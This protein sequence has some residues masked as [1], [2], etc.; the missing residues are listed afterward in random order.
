MQ[1]RQTEYIQTNKLHKVLFTYWIVLVVWQNVQDLVLL[2]ALDIIIKTCL[3]VYLIVS[4]L[5]G[6]RSAVPGINSLIW[7]VMFFAMSTTCISNSGGISF[8]NFIQYVFPV[9]LVFLVYLK[10][11]DYIITETEYFKYLDW[12]IY[13]VLYMA[14]YSFIF[15]GSYFSSAFSIS[16]AYGSALSSFLTSNHEYGMYLLFG[17]AACL[18]MMNINP[19][20]K[21]FYRISLVVFFINLIF[22]Y[23]RTSQI[24]AIAFL[25]IYVIFNDSTKLK[26]TYFVVVLSVVV[27]VLTIPSLN[28]FT[29]DILIRQDKNAGRFEMWEYALNVFNS[30]SGIQ[31]TFGHGYGFMAT[32]YNVTKHTSVHNAYLQVLLTNGVVGLG[33]LICGI[34]GSIKNAIRLTHINRWQGV[35]FLALSVSMAF[36]MFSNTAVIFY[37]LIDSSML[38]FFCIVAPKYFCNYKILEFQSHEMLLGEKQ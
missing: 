37:S 5:R 38:T 20:K 33:I 31:K 26:I 24:A 3:I 11:N 27:A 21:F 14:V 32:I 30:S 34:I 22:T 25:T 17:I 4:F 8:R 28:H 10:G 29:V 12:I 9:I 13:V 23:S 18:F 1:I 7:V 6:S 15:K 35:F 19:R 16:I 36:I 2:S